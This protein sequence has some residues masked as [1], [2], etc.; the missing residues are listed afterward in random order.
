M[1]RPRPG[2]TWRPLAL[3]AALAWG[4]LAGA[5]PA[6]AA[7]TVRVATFATGLGGEGPGLLLRDLESGEA[8]RVE[9]VLAMI[10]EAAPDILVLQGIDWDANGATL[11]ALAERIA[12]AGPDYP[13]R[14][15]AQP[16]TGIPT[17]FDLDGDGW[18]G[19]PRDRQGYGDYTG[20]GG[21][22]ILSRHPIATAE[23]RDLSALLWADLPGAIPPDLAPGVAAIQRLSSV[24]HWA[25]P[26]RIG[27]VTLT[28]LT[29]HATPPVFDGPE[30][31]NGRR[32]RDEAAL[33]LRLLDGALGVPPP[34]APFVL[35]GVANVDPRDGEGRRDALDALLSD[36]RLRDP[37]PRSEGGAAAADPGHA[38]DP[39]TDTAAYGPPAGNLRASYILPSAGL[40]V[41]DAGVLWPALGTAAAGRLGPAADWP[42]HRL[43]WVDLELRG[44]GDY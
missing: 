20:A 33:W 15:A 31:R 44:A 2:R 4:A 18:R 28:L 5:G 30:D 9:A 6:A 38:G 1:T 32:N 23:V 14:F 13:H 10:A 26:V 3:A 22:A 37:R 27:E 40:G 35:A 25:V 39:A 17:P 7:D 42:A 16:N 36:P 21:M 11:S 43:V 12:A 34:A 8:P 19:G 24:A 29:W 41:A